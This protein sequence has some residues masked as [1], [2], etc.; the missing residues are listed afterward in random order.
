MELLK[1]IFTNLDF[2]LNTQNKT[3]VIV[4]GENHIQLSLSPDNKVHL[5]TNLLLAAP[6]NSE[7]LSQNESKSD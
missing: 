1:S 6:S 5:S 3:L 7:L 2:H 4:Y